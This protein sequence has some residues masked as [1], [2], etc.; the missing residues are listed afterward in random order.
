MEMIGDAPMIVH[1]WRRACESKMGRVI[2]AT[3]AQEIYDAIISAG[4][5]AQ[6]TR[7]DHQSGSDRIAEALENA[8]PG[9]HASKIVNLQGD[10][11]T[12]DPTLVASCLAPLA[13]EDNTGTRADIATLAAPIIDPAERDNPNV[14]KIVAT[15]VSPSSIA[16]QRQSGSQAPQRLRALYFT[17]ATAPHGDGPHYHHIGIYA[18]TRDALD[19]FIA[20]PQSPL[21]Q[22]EKLEQLRALEAGMRIDVTVV[23]TIPLGVDTP[24]D[25]Q[26]AKDII[27]NA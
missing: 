7:S 21:E 22:R 19:R 11:P 26:K 12:L 27:A 6:M 8:D 13:S 16:S 10:L 5:Q 18:Y 1:V 17:R 3:D 4:G 14:V 9:R 24:A 15:P 2:V 20:L 25:L 23:D